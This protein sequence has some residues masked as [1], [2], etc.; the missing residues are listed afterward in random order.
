M[1]D[2]VLLILIKQV[3]II[4]KNYTTSKETVQ[5]LN[6]RYSNKPNISQLSES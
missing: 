4:G 1:L 6:G 2:I 3:F 5:I